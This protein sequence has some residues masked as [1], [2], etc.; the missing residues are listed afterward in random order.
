MANNKIMA[1]FV[2]LI[3]AVSAGA[4][5]GL[6]KDNKND[7]SGY[8]HRTMVFG[9]A[10]GDDKLDESD[11][12]TLNMIISEGIEDWE[13]DYPFADANQDG[14]ID[15]KDIDVV[16]KYLNDEPTR[17]YYV[18]AFDRVTWVNF[19]LGDKIGVETASIEFLPI[20][21]LYDKLYATD[22]GYTITTYPDKYPNAQ[23]K[24]I[25]GSQKSFTVEQVMKSGVETL[26]MYPVHGDYFWD[27][28]EESGLAD[29]VSVIV[30]DT[31]GDRAV[32][33]VL[34]LGI[35]FK[36]QERAKLYADWYDEIVSKLSIIGDTV[37]KKE[38]NVINGWPVGFTKGEFTVC[39]SEFRP[40]GHYHH[41]IDFQEKYRGPANMSV[42]FEN[43]INSCTDDIIVILHRNSDI[44][45][46]DFGSYCQSRIEEAFPHTE[47]LANGTIY[48]VEWDCSPNLGGIAGMYL[49][50]SFI[51]P[52]YFD[53]ETGY[54]YLQYFL[55]NF[56]AQTGF[57]AHAGFVYAIT[58]TA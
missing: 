16:N 57:D 46:E 32:G 5:Y 41:I 12:D 11:I 14:V 24:V 10:N 40:V 20:L 6:S 35:F 42:N 37:E 31:Q 23:D 54:E 29:T 15:Q 52:E 56:H 58:P 45:P 36:V 38:V 44:L 8:N 53:T 27:K 18:N 2:V 50:A 48:A 4:V 21:G 13:E 26:F 1:V 33:D 47:Q 30:L 51:Y 7:D 49:L 28:A 9:N 19:P 43:F 39:G 3:L 34:M 17:L 25:I 55:D 22:S